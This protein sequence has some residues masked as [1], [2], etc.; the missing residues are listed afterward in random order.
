MGY[1]NGVRGFMEFGG[2]GGRCCAGLGL[3]CWLGAYSGGCGCFIVFWESVAAGKY[4]YSYPPP[5]NS[6]PGSQSFQPVSADSGS[7]YSNFPYT[8]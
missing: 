4:Q 7:H 1:C 8:S 6:T 3:G 2:L 5:H